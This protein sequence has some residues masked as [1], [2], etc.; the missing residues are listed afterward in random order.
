MVLHAKVRVKE[1]LSQK[2]EDSQCPEREESGLILRERFVADGE[3][4]G[5]LNLWHGQEQEEDP[6]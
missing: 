1:E 6:C 5:V 4:P 2:L 3:A